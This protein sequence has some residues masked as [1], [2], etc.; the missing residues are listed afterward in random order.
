MGCLRA[1]LLSNTGTM[2]WRKVYVP[3]PITRNNRM[4]EGLSI[5]IVPNN[6]SET[7]TNRYLFSESIGWVKSISIPIRQTRGF[8]LSAPI[9]Y[10]PNNTVLKMSIDTYLLYQYVQINRYNGLLATQLIIE[11]ANRY[12][13]LA[14]IGYEKYPSIP[15]AGNNRSPIGIGSC[16]LSINLEPIVQ[17]VYYIAL[18]TELL[19]QVIK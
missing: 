17:G 9:S 4:V 1:P 11:D 7:S 14:P 12:P 8:R 5:P 13:L 15:I 19:S 16:R 6:R 2:Q 18:P 10:G 3:M